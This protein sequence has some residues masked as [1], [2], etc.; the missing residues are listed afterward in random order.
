[1]TSRGEAQIKAALAAFHPSELRVDEARNKQDVR[2]YLTELVKAHVELEVTMESLQREVEDTFPGLAGH[3]DGFSDLEDPLRR[4]KAVYDDA[5]RGVAGV[6]ALAGYQ[7]RRDADLKQAS[8][9][10]EAIY[11]DAAEA[12][13]ILVAALRA[14]P[15]ELSDSGPPKKRKEDLALEASSD[16]G[17]IATQSRELQ[18]VTVQHPLACVS[19]PGR[20]RASRAA[21]PR[22]G[23]SRTNTGATRAS[24]GTSRARRCS[25]RRAMI[26]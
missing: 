11:A 8:S 10:F 22:N 26:S 5:V 18:D 16:T 20:I 15:G 24:S 17:A 3:L 6:G 1:M 2:A 14:L 19:L 23:S 4:S 12:Q 9:D 25:S 13:T 7:E 21:R